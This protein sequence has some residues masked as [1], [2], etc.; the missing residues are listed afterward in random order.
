MNL[1][2][3]KSNVETFAMQAKNEIE[4]VAKMDSGSSAS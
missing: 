4:T 2:L 1:G 3:Y